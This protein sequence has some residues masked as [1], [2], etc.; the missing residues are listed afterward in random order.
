MLLRCRRGYTLVEIMIVVAV[1]AILLSVALPNYFKSGKT[2]SRNS[3]NI[4]L[5]QIDGAMEQWAMDNNIPEGTVPSGQQ[6]S[7]IYG[8]MDSGMPVC[9]SHGEY[10]IHAVGTKPQVT[11]SREDEGHKLPA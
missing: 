10:F 4:N 5:R 3:C 8:Y 1:L 9:P 6:E 11:C 2:T 7:E